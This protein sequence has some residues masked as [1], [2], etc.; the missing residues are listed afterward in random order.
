MLKYR[1]FFFS[2]RYGGTVYD[3]FRY[4]AIP[5]DKEFN[6]IEKASDWLQMMNERGKVSKKHNYT[7][8]PVVE[9]D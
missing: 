9:F 8:L 5:E 2:S 1:I 4:D 7:I 3:A 6:S